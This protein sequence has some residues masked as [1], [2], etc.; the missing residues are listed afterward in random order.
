MGLEFA[1]QLAGRGYDLILVSN[2]EVE[3]KAAAASIRDQY[4]VE[5]IYRFQDLAQTDAADQLYA[6]C[7]VEQGLLPDVVINDAGMF[8]FKEL[9]PEDLD[10]AQAMVNLHV[11]TVTRICLLFGNAMKERGSGF[12]LN[13]SSMAARIPAPG[14]SAAS[15]PAGSLCLHSSSP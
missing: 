7:A 15:P 3:L 4:P 1:R 9:M 8:F 11:V 5:V 10:R 13:L 6:W 2:R 14:R 12:L